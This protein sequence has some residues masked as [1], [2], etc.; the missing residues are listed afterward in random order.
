[1][2][3][4]GLLFFLNMTGRRLYQTW[5]R[6]INRYGKDVEYHEDLHCRG[7]PCKVIRKINNRDDNEAKR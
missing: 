4:D 2:K 5:Q 6:P 7:Y 3:R 1:M